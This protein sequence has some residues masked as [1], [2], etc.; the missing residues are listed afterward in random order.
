M[1]KPAAERNVVMICPNLKCR[2]VL[3]VP[4]QFRGQRVRCHYCNTTFAVPLAKTEKSPAPRHT[5]SNDGAKS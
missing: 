2:K 3:Q 1:S 5:P 4:A